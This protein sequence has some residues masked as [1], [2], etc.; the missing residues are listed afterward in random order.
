MAPGTLRP[1]P[2]LQHCAH[3]RSQN[4]RTRRPAPFTRHHHE[5]SAACP[6][7]LD[8]LSARH[9]AGQPLHL[10][11]H[12]RVDPLCMVNRFTRQRIVRALRMERVTNWKLENLT[13]QGIPLRLQ[14]YTPDRK[15]HPGVQQA[16][17]PSFFTRPVPAAITRKGHT[18]RPRRNLAA[19]A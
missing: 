13:G 15:L 10:T 3:Q 11:L 18:S 12:L 7:K 19:A 16:T 14:A 9:S 8:P 6:A 4:T 2:K 5:R 1:P 17:Q